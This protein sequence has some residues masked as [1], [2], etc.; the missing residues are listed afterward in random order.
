V[1]VQVDKPY[2]TK[3][4]IE[5]SLFITDCAQGTHVKT[6]LSYRPYSLCWASAVFAIHTVSRVG[7][8]PIFMQ[9]VVIILTDFYCFLSGVVEPS[10]SV[11]QLHFSW[12]LGIPHDLG[13]LLERIVATVVAR[14]IVGMYCTSDS[15]LVSKII[16]V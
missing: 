5:S 10:M 14:V 7:I 11:C 1:E 16:F 8:T 13:S 6:D 15:G 2:K 3:K 9:F 4:F 12:E